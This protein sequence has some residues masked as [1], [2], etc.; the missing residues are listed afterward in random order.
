MPFRGCRATA[1]RC[2]RGGGRCARG[3]AVEGAGGLRAE[4]DASALAALAPADGGWPVPEVDVGLR[5]GG[6]LAGAGAGL[7]HEPDTASSRRSRS[8]SVLEHAASSARISSAD[9]GWNSFLVELRPREPDQ[10]IGRG[11]AL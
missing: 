8:G 5:H 9:S 7:G 2:R 10:R 1:P 3:V 11:L 6:D 4:E